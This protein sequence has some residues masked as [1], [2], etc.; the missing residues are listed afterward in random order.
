MRSRYLLGFAAALGIAGT[1]G[2]QP[3]TGRGVPPT[4]QG[5]GRVNYLLPPVS[6]R[7][8]PGEP[9]ARPAA[10][11]RAEPQQ[12][13]VV[14]E[15][16]WAAP[17][18]AR[19]QPAASLPPP[20]VTQVR[21]QE[22]AAPPAKLPEVAPPP[23]PAPPKPATAAPAITAPVASGTAFPSPTYSGPFAPGATVPCP[24]PAAACPPVK[25]EPPCAP[26]PSAWVRAEWLFWVTSGQSLPPIASTSPL[27]TARDVA[28]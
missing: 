10:D 13:S 11:P 26:V 28:G 21:H 25:Y 18:T 1:A 22:P 2:A 4:W 15:D 7:G 27:G 23:T 6:S 16:I 5:P 17:G 24:A 20:T 19:P 9:V 14:T 3:V 8:L 12:P